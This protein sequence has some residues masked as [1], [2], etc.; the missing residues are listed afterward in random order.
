MIDDASCAMDLTELAHRKL[1]LGVTRYVNDCCL[2]C[3][4]TWLAFCKLIHLL[5]T[6][7]LFS[8][9]TINLID[10]EASFGWF[11][12]SV[13]AALPF[14]VRCSIAFVIFL[15]WQWPLQMSLRVI[16]FVEIKIHTVLITLSFEDFVEII[17]PAQFPPKSWPI[18]EEEKK[19]KWPSKK[20][21]I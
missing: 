1:S 21:K 17:M 11:V 13:P 3:S 9:I 19:C 10:T 20:M 4:L 16:D 12:M 18:K 2:T 7:L 8:P 5:Y 15:I 14:H 6:L